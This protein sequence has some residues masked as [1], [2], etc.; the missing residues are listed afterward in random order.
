MSTKEKNSININRKKLSAAQ[1]KQKEN[2][3]SVLSKHKMLTKRPVYKQK[4][5]YFLVFLLL[6]LTLLIYYADKEEAEN[7]TQTTAQEH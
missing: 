6:I 5:F 2:L 7:N 3:D 4:K 1:V